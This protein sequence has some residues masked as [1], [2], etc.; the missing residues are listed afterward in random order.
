[1]CLVEKLS[2]LVK[3]LSMD[4]FCRDLKGMTTAHVGTEDQ[5]L[6]CLAMVQI[7]E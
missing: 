5:A 3:S 6:N 2:E 4:F 7:P 1:M